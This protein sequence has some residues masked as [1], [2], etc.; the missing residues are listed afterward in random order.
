MSESVDAVGAGVHPALAVSVSARVS[1]L[2]P[3]PQ[4]ERLI[5]WPAAG[6]GDPPAVLATFP[7][8][9]CLWVSGIEFSWFYSPTPPL[10]LDRSQKGSRVGVAGMVWGSS[11]VSFLRVC[12]YLAVLSHPYWPFLTLR[13]CTVQA[14]KTLISN[15]GP[16]HSSLGNRHQYS[17]PVLRYWSTSV[18]GTTRHLPC[19][20]LRPMELWRWS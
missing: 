8:P 2:R 13:I 12:V 5:P 16:V 4:P 20:V 17:T 1:V 19:P 6:G 10:R 11:V 9:Q 14:I 18:P 3:Q 15:Q 7:H